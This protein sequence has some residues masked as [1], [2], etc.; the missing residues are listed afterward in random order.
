[1]SKSPSYLSITLDDA[2]LRSI[3]EE[4]FR[5]H[6]FVSEGIDATDVVAKFVDQDYDLFEPL[7]EIT[8]TFPA[9]Q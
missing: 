8:I 1:M 3:I 4:H 7:C 6:D 9:E 5:K 2:Q